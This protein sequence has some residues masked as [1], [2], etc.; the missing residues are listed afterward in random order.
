MGDRDR[1]TGERAGAQRRVG[2]ERDA[3]FTEAGLRID[4]GA[5]EPHAPLERLRE[6]RQAHYGGICDLHLREILLRQ[7]AAHLDFAAARDPEQGR[8]ARVGDLADLG[9]AREHCPGDRRDDARAVETR[10]GLRELRGHDLDVRRIR[11]RGGAAFLD[12]LGRERPGRLD[13]LCTAILGRRQGS[14]RLRLLERGREPVDLRD[15]HGVVELREQLA[16]AHVIAG[17]DVNGDDAPGVPVVADRHVVA[18]GNRP[19]ER[20]RRGHGPKSRRHD[21]DERDVTLLGERHDRRLVAQ[22]AE[23]QR[24]DDE[25]R[26]DGCGAEHVLAEPPGLDGSR[27]GRE[28]RRGPRRALRNDAVESGPIAADPGDVLVLGFGGAHDDRFRVSGHA[29]FLWS[30]RSRA[31]RRPSRPD[32]SNRPFKQFKRRCRHFPPPTRQGEIR[33]RRAET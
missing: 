5:E 31:R 19:G 20:Y 2:L 22:R 32:P 23:E 12:V 8:P 1:A 10:L 13:A 4:D 27:L 28:L 17:L 24:A 11:Y 25:R 18:G 30:G 15:E 6:S 9:A 21:G 3:N 7:L 16:L 29:D 14:L 26:A 33:G